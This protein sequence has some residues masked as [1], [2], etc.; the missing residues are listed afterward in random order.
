MNSKIVVKIEMYSD[1]ACPWCHLGFRRLQRAIQ[2]ANE[3]GIE[4]EV[5]YKP[6]LIDPNTNSKG[7]DYMSYNVRRWGGDRWTQ[8]LRHSGLSDNTA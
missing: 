4:T 8:S 1:I 2:M 5:T 3:K 6:V 7:E